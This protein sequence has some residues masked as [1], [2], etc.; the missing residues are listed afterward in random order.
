MKQ[1][2]TDKELLLLVETQPGIT[3]TQVAE[4]YDVGT[5]QANAR[6]RRLFNEGKLAR[7]DISPKGIRGINY[8]YALSNGEAPSPRPLKRSTPTE[9]GWKARY[10]EALVEVDRLKEWQA[11]AL[12]RYPDLAVPDVVFRARQIVAKAAP[13]HRAEALDGRLDKKPIM[14]VTIAALEEML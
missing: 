3:A 12:R 7:K 9:N 1:V 8:G 11:E 4:F 14:L 13:E 6:L 5:A 10:N 2:I